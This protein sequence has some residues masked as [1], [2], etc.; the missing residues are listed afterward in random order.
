MS[1]LHIDDFFKDV[2][3]ILNQL[4]LAFPRKTTVYIEDVAG[5]D[6]PDEFGL[7]SDRH[8][9]CL[10]ALV[11]L[12]EE[13]YIRFEDT[14]R[15][16]AVDQAVLS[17]RSFSVLSAAAVDVRGDGG[18]EET[19]PSGLARTAAHGFGGEMPASVIRDQSTNI[20]RLRLALRSKSSDRIREVTLDLLR[21]AAGG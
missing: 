7:H 4:Y 9:A 12:S 8:L 1:D 18:L 6:E 15:Q 21:Q 17:G 5:H 2:A 19:L 3:R 16:E 10:G 20:T 11:W 14:I 13:G